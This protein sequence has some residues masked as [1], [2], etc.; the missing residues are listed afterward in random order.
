MAA[1]TVLAGGPE[2]A[3]GPG[4]TGARWYVADLD[5]LAGAAE[6]V[7][8]RRCS[9]PIWRWPQLPAPDDAAARAG[10]SGPALPARG[11]GCAGSGG[12]R[13]P[14]RRDRSARPSVR[15]SIAGDAWPRMRRGC[16]RVAAG[17][18]ARFG[19]SPTPVQV[20]A[21]VLDGPAVELRLAVRPA[22]VRVQAADGT[23]I[24]REDPRCRRTLRDPEA[25]EEAAG[26]A[27]GRIRCALFRGER[28]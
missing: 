15:F 16:D 18:A 11:A 24:S 2:G 28:R 4:R 12:A 22:W 1:W 19:R 8:D 9:R 13:R 17:R 6:S 27:G 25:T 3:A 23:V 10:G 20:G 5:P 14:D 21:E 26:A 7:A